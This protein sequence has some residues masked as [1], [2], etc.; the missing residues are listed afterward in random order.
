M[1]T[2]QWGQKENVLTDRK[3][4]IGAQVASGLEHRQENITTMVVRPQIFKSELK[5]REM[6][7]LKKKE[8]I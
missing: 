1:S 5:R 8:M 2:G 6:L 4:R 7:L 3:S